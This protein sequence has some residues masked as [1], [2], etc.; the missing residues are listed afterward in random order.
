M[1]SATAAGHDDWHRGFVGGYLGLPWIGAGP[2]DIE[3][4]PTFYFNPFTGDHDYTVCSFQIGWGAGV[5]GSAGFAFSFS[6]DGTP[7]ELASGN[8]RFTEIDTPWID[9]GYSWTDDYEMHTIEVGWGVD[10]G[11]TRGIRDIEVVLVDHAL[12]IRGHSI[13]SVWSPR[14]QSALRS[15]NHV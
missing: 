5:G 15:C 2:I 4:Q 8:C 7:G 9:Y 1:A 10:A 6:P 13:Y 14:R 3:W 12:P 11:I